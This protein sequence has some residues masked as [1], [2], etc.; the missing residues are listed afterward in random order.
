MTAANVYGVMRREGVLVDARVRGGRLERL[1]LLP[2]LLDSEGYPTLRS[3]AADTFA[4][5][6]TDLSA[7]MGT[8]FESVA[9]VVRVNAA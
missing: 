7:G 5:L 9:G 4:E 2:V 1:T 6:M 3:D 8:A